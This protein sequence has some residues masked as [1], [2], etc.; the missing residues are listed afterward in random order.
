MTRVQPL[1]VALLTAA[2]VAGI[3]A[4]G[5]AQISVALPEVTGDPDEQVDIPIAIGDLT[6]QGAFSYLF[7]IAYDPA[8]VKISDVSIE[9][10][11]SAGMS[12][13]ANT[14]RSG[15]LRVSAAHT[16]PLS[17]SGVLLNLKARYVG[18]G[19]SPLHW[20]EFTFNEGDP[21]ASAVDGSVGVHRVGEPPVV[22]PPI[23]VAL[24]DVSGLAG[25]EF[26]LPVEVE[27][28][29]EKGVMAYY[30]TIVY[31][32][33]VMGFE[34]VSAE[35]TLSEGMTVLA[36][37]EVP[38]ELRVA[39]SHTDSI[40]GAGV[41][42]NLQARYV[43]RGSTALHW[44]EFTFNEGSP[45]S[46]PADGAASARMGLETGIGVLLP[47]IA[48]YAGERDLLPVQVEELSGQE[49]FSYLFT[50]IYDPTILQIR[51]VSTAGTISE[52]MGVQGNSLGPGRF[53]VA[54]SSA[55]ALEGAGHLIDLEV[56]FVGGGNS[57]LRWG[58]F[59]FNERDPAPNPIDGQAKA[60][61]EIIFNEIHSGPSPSV[62][63]VELL[64]LADH[65]DLR[66]YRVV[67]SSGE[68][69]GFADDSLWRDLRRGT[70][71]LVGGNDSPLV[72]DA[73]AT[74]FIVSVRNDPF[75]PQL[76]LTGGLLDIQEDNDA[77][78]LLRPSEEPAFAV[79]WGGWIW[80]RR[81]SSAWIWVWV[82]S[83][84]R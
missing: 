30:F 15:E 25:E 81:R 8:V 62:D 48:G 33:E 78:Q 53:T 61:G 38:G 73:D 36:N 45:P 60:D 77:V 40:S 7:T 27:D 47:K 63:W 16:E 2:L 69:F 10:T 26:L 13:V 17:G 66:G 67:S 20:V 74:D 84:G 41:L 28:L 31:D 68:G 57:T 70:L 1:F 76:L 34:G 3:P 42:L 5:A 71:I 64:V 9:G 21:S 82:H 35:G 58:E 23:G 4:V 56:E 12:V 19:D 24:P 55:S 83:L 65:L 72:D 46:T 52:G 49:V 39:A 22:H 75:V 79:L 18:E 6:D 54:A 44:E 11:L 29:T 37:T 43:G 50:V 51:G 14:G 32:A 80:R 59:Y